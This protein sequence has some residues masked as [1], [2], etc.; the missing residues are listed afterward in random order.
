MLRLFAHAAAIV[1]LYVAFSVAMML[2]LQ[3]SVVYGNIGLLVVGVLVAL[4]VYFGFVRKR[5]R[6]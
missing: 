1:A 4:Y 2:G 3:V 6:P 5:R